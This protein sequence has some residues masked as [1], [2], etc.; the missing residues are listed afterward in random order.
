MRSQLLVAHQNYAASLELFMNAFNVWEELEAQRNAG[1]TRSGGHDGPEFVPGVKKLRPHCEPWTVNGTEVPDRNICGVVCRNQPSCMGF[2]MDETSG[3]CLWFDDAEPQSEA[4]CSMQTE[5]AY[6]RR[7]EQKDNATVWATM[8][9]LQVFDKAIINTLNL[10]DSDSAK[11]S[12]SYA[13]WTDFEGKNATLKDEKEQSFSDTL[14]NYTK[15]LFDIEELRKQYLVLQRTAYEL[16]EKEAKA[17]PPFP[18][19]PKPEPTE[20]PLPHGFVAPQA[21]PPKLI[22]WTDFPN[23]QDTEWAK[24]HPDCPEGVPCF[25]D[26]RCRGAPPQNFV[27]PPPVPTTPCPQMQPAMVNPLVFSAAG[28]R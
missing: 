15:A 18:P 4:A 5:T 20:P 3:W 28:A 11:T 26:C 23:S 16:A 27:E 25:C 13:D 14:N 8:K 2:A 19:P 1:W 7:W 21:D 12:S 9:K 17:N 6:I 24:L 22:K 10:V